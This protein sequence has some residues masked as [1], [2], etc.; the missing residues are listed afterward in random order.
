M[1]RL[2]AVL[3]ST[4]FVLFGGPT[5]VAGLVPWLLTRWD[6]DESP[7]LLRIA[8][9]ALIAAG[10]ALV[11]ETTA[12]FALQG[13]GT[14]VPFAAPERFVAHGSYRVVRNPMYVGVLA[15]I[16]GQ[17]FLLGREVLLVWAVAAAGFFHL[18]VV[19]HEEPELR[20]RFGAEYDD[21]RRRVGRWLPTTN[22]AR[23][24]RRP[25]RPERRSR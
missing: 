3:G 21:Y 25:A 10:A 1:T 23:S 14:P 6:A 7:L 16:V 22:L 2:R 4:A 15:L 5:I 9:G 19:L 8:G 24:P 20:R 13:R 12:R 11:V 18:F 17:A